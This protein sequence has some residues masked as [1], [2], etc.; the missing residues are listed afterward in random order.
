MQVQIEELSPVEKKIA[1]E[2]PWERVRE[3]LDVA[4]RQLGKDVKLKGF[5]PGKVPRAV[6]EKMFAKQVH[7]EVAKELVQESF[8]SVAQEHKL[9]PVA[10][11]VVE[12]ARIKP[13][14]A[15]RYSARV[16]VRSPVELKETDK[17]PAR[18]RPISVTDEEV[19]HTLEHQRMQHAEYKPIDAAARPNTAATDVLVVSAKG[20]VGAHD[21]DRPD[22]QID[23]GHTDHEPLPGM[24]RLLTG[25]P[26][27][28]KDKVLTLDIPADWQQKE[29]AGAHAELTITIKD[30]REKVVPALD[31]EFAKDTGEADTLV[32]LKQKIR[33]KLEAQQRAAA[34]RDM[35]TALQKEFVKRNPLPIAPALVERGIDSQLER[36]RYSLAMQGIDLD[37]VGVDLRS[38]R[39]RLRDNATEEI[40][41]QLLLEA[42]ADREKI[43][44][45]D[46]DLDNKIVEMAKA[47]EKPPAKVKAEMDRDGSLESLRW[48]LRQEKALDLL[49]SRATITEAPDPE[50]PAADEKDKQEK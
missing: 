29:I 40:Q 10:E 4:F 44:V 34:E 6:V 43:E 35:R 48:R 3:K 42:L 38:M 20:K 45:T 1:V 36:T 24:A 17:L 5:R 39:E 15:F 22:L 31:D 37:A 32:D 9:E 41:G 50:P 21:I 47:R 46:A 18:R 23:L 12:D 11:P 14:E 30:A 25:I 7:L 49:V 27:D 33:E 16:E 13:N 26:L 8:L 2:I 28:T 19:M